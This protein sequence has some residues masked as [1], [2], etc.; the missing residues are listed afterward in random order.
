MPRPPPPATALIRTGKADLLGGGQGLLLAADRACGAGYYRQAQLHRRGLGL[1]LVAHDPDVLRGRADEG[2]AVLLDHLREVGVLGEEAVAGVDGIGPGDL[3][4]GQ[5]RHRVQVGA[6]GGRRADTDA[7][8]GQA[9]MHGLGVDGGVH[10]HG[11]DAHLVAGAQD[12]DCHLAAIGDQDLL[13][14][15]APYSSTRSGSPYSTG[16]AFSMK[17]RPMRPA[18]GARIAFMTFMASMMRR[19]WPSFTVSPV[20]TNGAAPGS[21]ER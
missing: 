15:G 16:A 5:D 1:D 7:L 18:R 17:I 12:P 8:V 3:G 4:R 20:L 6:L 19:V 14:Q 10:G 9:H 2:E 11:R 21:P 13:E